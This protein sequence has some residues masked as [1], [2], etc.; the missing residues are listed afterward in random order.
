MAACIHTFFCHEHEIS[1]KCGPTCTI[2]VKNVKNKIYM[3]IFST[4]KYAETLELDHSQIWL[5]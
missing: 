4:G 2:N 5:L 3:P 1:V